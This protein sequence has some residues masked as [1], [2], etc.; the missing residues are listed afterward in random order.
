MP[1]PAQVVIVGAGLAGLVTAYELA[2]R[3][4]PSVVLESDSRVGGR[5]HT[6]T[7]ADGVTA[8]AHMEEFW[9]GSPA[10]GLLRRLRLPVSEDVAHSS[11]ML[12]GGL[13]PYAGD[14]D[15]ETYLRG[16]FDHRQRTA[17]LEWNAT[18]CGVLGDRPAVLRDGQDTS[19]RLRTMRRTSFRDF[20]EGMGLPRRVA[21]WIRIVVESETAVEWHRIAALDGIDEMRPFL[22]TPQG[23]GER[24]AHVVGGNGRLIEALVNELPSGCVR[25]NAR[26][27][28]V[29]DNGSGVAVQYEDSAWRQRAVCGEFAALTIPV[30][31]LNAISLEPA[32]SPAARD[33]IDSTGAGCYVKVILRVRADAAALWAH[34]G[35]S[36]FTL[37]TDS[38]AGC[39]YLSNPSGPG[40]DLVLTM[41]IHGR[42]ARAFAHR[43]ADSIARQAITALERLTVQESPGGHRAR[44][45]PGISRYVTDARV[46]KCPRAVAYWPQARGRSRFD[47]LAAELR[48]PHGRVLIGGDTTES[49]HSEGAFRSAQ[50]MTA[51]ILQHLG[52]REAAL[53]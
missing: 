41:L 53:L 47:A 33:A 52:V 31:D 36:L 9:E 19:A 45:M 22:D 12:A 51:A 26:V 50:R 30:W 34:H 18:A 3:D 42:F 14:G 10:Y 40:E 8:E 13:Y 29:I 7:F 48:V 35:P 23:F 25:N 11:V 39:L 49:S 37:L 44:L 28:R 6:I 21:E 20:V 2:R 1:T 27:N 43:P 46:F 17:F 38:R 5:V 16:M 15:R 4:I 24:N 32:L